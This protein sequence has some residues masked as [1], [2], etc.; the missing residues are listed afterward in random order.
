MKLGFVGFWTGR[1]IEANNLTARQLFF[2]YL[3]TMQDDR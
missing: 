2:S 1:Y 3:P